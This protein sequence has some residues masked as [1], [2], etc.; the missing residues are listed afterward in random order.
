MFKVQAT[1]AVVSDIPG[2]N[3]CEIRWGLYYKTLQIRNL[4]QMARFRS[5]LVLFL[6]S[7]TNPLAWTNTPGYYGIRT[8]L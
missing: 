7:V 4:Q 2:D 8:V 6:L 3:P 5:K 1:G